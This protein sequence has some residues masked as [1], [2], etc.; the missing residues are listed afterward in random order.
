[1]DT[2]AKLLLTTC[3]APFQLTHPEK[4]ITVRV[5]ADGKL[6]DR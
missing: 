5:N 6:P 3:T 2:I 1:M 4:T